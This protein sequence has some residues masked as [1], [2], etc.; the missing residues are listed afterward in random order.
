MNLYNK[1]FTNYFFRAV[2]TTSILRYK[3][4]EPLS[5][6]FICCGPFCFYF[7]NL[8]DFSNRKNTDQSARVWLEIKKKSTL[9][10]LR[11][12]SWTIQSS[13]LRRDN[14]IAT[15][16]LS[17]DLICLTDLLTNL[18]DVNKYSIEYVLRDTLCKK[19]SLYER[20]VLSRQL[21]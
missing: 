9:K 1:L 11:F 13:E 17:R 18:G 5:E 21:E 7:T 20:I 15:Q 6:V 14:G 8:K 4:G 16:T 3:T 2:S 19:V 10:T 12:T